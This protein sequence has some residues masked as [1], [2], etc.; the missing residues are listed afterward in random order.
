VG[1]ALYFAYGFRHSHLRASD[2]ADPG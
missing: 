1:I 2:N